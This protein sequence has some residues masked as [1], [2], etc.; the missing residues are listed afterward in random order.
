MRKMRP[1]HW[2]LQDCIKG[3]SSI[4][5]SGCWEWNRSRDQDGYGHLS[6]ERKTVRAHRLSW[7]AFYGPIPIGIQVCHTCD[8]PCCVNPSHLWLGTNAD[9]TADRTRKGRESRGNSHTATFINNPKWWAARPKGSSHVNSKINEAQARA[10]LNDTRPQRV[11]AVDYGVA[12]S[13]I[14]LVKRRKLWAHVS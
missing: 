3:Y 2:S 1:S 5:P 13:L 9:N 8:N 12:Q 10:I 6:W 14:S 4:V 11:I 7:M